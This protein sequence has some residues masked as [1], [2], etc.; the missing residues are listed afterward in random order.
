MQENE[1]EKKY[2]AFVPIHFS[3]VFAVILY[4]LVIFFLN[5]TAE[6]K[7]IETATVSQN[8]IKT[9]SIATLIYLFACMILVPHFRK[10]WINSY[11]P[12]EP[13]KFDANGKKIIFFTR[14]ISIYFVAYAIIDAGAIVGIIMFLF[15]GDAVYSYIC[16]GFS[17]LV[18][19]I[20]GPNKKELEILRQK[21]FVD[22]STNQGFT[23]I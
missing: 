13:P 22:I 2:K 17:A 9:I 20:N 12:F 3:L 8:T 1:L 23:V 7:I 10:K 6:G 18:M 5:D 15:G 16:I 14:Y 11:K 21:E 19:A 4:A